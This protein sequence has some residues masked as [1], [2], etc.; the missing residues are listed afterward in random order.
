MTIREIQ[1]AVSRAFGVTGIDLLSRRQDIRVARP[2]QVAVWLARHLTPC[3]L[4]EIGRE[5]GRDHTS[6]GA[7]ISR[8]D[9]LLASDKAFAAVVWRLMDALDHA[10]TVELRR[11][12]VR[13]VA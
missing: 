8:I 9:T 10:A 11:L 2:R 13:A 12:Q 5:F 6:V 4:S 7:A 3:S 1:A